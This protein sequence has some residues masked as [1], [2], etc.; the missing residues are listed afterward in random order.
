MALDRQ[1]RYSLTVVSTG[2]AESGTGESC[3]ERIAKVDVDKCRPIRG[4]CRV[5]DCKGLVAEA[6]EGKAIE[7]MRSL[8]TFREECRKADER[9]A[10]TDMLTGCEQC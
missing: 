8:R 3:E 1:L 10:V 6:A 2:I 5:H 9:T 4:T 7:G